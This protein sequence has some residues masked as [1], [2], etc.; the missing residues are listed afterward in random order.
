MFWT[1]ILC[2]L[3]NTRFTIFPFPSFCPCAGS[4]GTNSELSST[5]GVTR[6]SQ[7]V[8]TTT[9]LISPTLLLIYFFFL[10]QLLYEHSKLAEPSVNDVS[11]DSLMSLEEQLEIAL[12]VSRARKVSVLLL[13]DS[14]NYSIKSSV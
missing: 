2:L 14:T 10:C 9:P 8:S 3:E 6:I 11:V 1:Y 5:Q 13:S 4:C 7:Q 12:S